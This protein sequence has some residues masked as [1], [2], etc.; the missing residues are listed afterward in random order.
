MFVKANHGFI[1][2]GY[3]PQSW[4][5]DFAYTDTKAAY[6]F[7]LTDGKNRRPMRCPVRSSKSHHAIKQNDAKYSPAFGEAN[8]SDLFIAFKNLSNS[9]SMVGNV[10]KLPEGQDSELF[11]A[12][13]KKDWEVE[14]VEIWAVQ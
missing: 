2:G 1:F 3:N 11:L 6:L 4:L 10:Y 8:I 12:G 9:Y 14:E 13:K 5:S 7:S